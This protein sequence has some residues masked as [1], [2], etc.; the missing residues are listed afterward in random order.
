MSEKL[1]HLDEKGNPNMVDVGK[2]DDTTRSATA[3]AIVTFPENVAAQLT[4]SDMKTKK[5]SITQ[6]AILAGIMGAKKTADLIPLCHP[7]PL[8]NCKLSVEFTSATE[9]RIIAT[10]GTTGKTGIEME[11]LTAVSIAALTVYDMVKGLSHDI[12]IGPIQLEAKS[13]GKRDY[14]RN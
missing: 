2:K 3:S 14:E 12:R 11:A 6:T 7:L 1:T 5:G 10:T 9:L 4:A 13:G 8:T